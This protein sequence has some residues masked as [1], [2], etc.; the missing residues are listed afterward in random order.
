MAP[1]QLVLGAPLTE[2]T[3]LFALGLVLY[4]LVVGQHPFRR[5]GKSGPPPPPSAV[6]AG[7]NPQLEQVILEALSP[8]PNERPASAAAMGARLPSGPMAAGPR[9]RRSWAAAVAVVGIVGLLLFF[10]ARTVPPRLGPLT[11]QDTIV[12]ADF[13]NTTGEPVFDGTL[14]VAL[15]VAL[16]QSPFLKVFPDQRVQETLRLMQR[17]SGEPVTRTVAREIAR[18][19]QLKALLTGSISSLGSHYVLALEAINAATGDV[20]AREQVEVAGKEGVLTALGNAA[21]RLREALGESL[22]SVERFDAP[23]ARATTPSLEALHAYSLALDEG[24]IVPRLAAIPHLQRAIE[25]DPNFALALALLSGV[26]SNTG[27]STEAPDLSRRAFEL[28]DRVSERERFFISW[29][30]YVDA[31]QAWDKALDLARSWTTTYPREPFAFN[32]L[33]LA[34][35]AFGEHEE[36]VRALREALR[37]DPRFLIAYGNLAG[38]LIALNRFDEAR[39]VV[40][41]GDSRKIVS[42][43]LRRMDYLLAFLEHDQAGMAR[44]LEAIK[45][46]AEAPWA[47]NWEPRTLVFGGKVQAAHRGFQAGAQVMLDNNLK[48]F[49]AQWTA[50]DAESHA[51]AGQCTEARREVAAALGLSRDN[52]TLERAS[53]TL[54][55]CGDTSE[56]PRLVEEL[57]KR[58][59]EAALTLRIHVPVTGA[60]MAVRGR[61][62]ARALALLEAVRPYDHAP[63]AEFWPSYLR[64]LAYLQAGDGGAA[65]AQF[66]A[67]IER[68]G[69]NIT[70]PLFVLAHLGLARAAALAG[71]GERARQA[72]ETFLELWKDADSNLE[73]IGEA[74]RE[75][76]RL[77]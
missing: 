5:S 21:A 28:R 53:R 9:R 51:L 66:Q 35:A 57:Q 16:E 23:L 48:E 19:E 37:V 34:A 25:L 17:D 77:Q 75:L 40:A 1:E 72:Y 45:G 3:D 30:Y 68:R 27:R 12:L 73:L 67:I 13:V 43:S 38:S 46:M 8:D 2:R 39:T 15:A 61:Q 6:V 33:G 31:T 29:R 11:E 64:G 74:R 54:A 32:S 47:S 10:A 60:A 70:S 62:S 24:R 49:A 76:M 18:R 52:F 58:F 63:A 55:Y 71:S 56:V 36:G 22:T 7:V 65:I 50:E 41:E 14:K 59:P 42:I 44:A 69:K 4:E 26:Y 20:V